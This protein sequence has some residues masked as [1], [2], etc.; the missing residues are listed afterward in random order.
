MFK[1]YI[2]LIATLLLVG[3]G[4]D[5]K[6]H[7]KSRMFQSVNPQEATLVQSGKDKSSCL[8]CGMNLVKYYKTSHA[9]EIN[10]KHYQYCSIHCLED[11]LGDGVTL[12]HPRVVDVDSLKLISVA[13]ANYVVGS[14]KRGTMTRVSKYA[15]SDKKMAQKFQAT[16]GGEIMNFSEALKISKKDFKH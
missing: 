10:G 3:C 15:F 2:A 11:H 16:Y 14:K 13:K 6:P 1:V 9:A 4:P 5:K 12:K 8:R 7:V